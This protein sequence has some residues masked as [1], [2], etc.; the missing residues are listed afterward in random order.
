MDYYQRAEIEGVVE[1]E[2]TVLPHSVQAEI[3]GIPLLDSTGAEITETVEPTYE[4]REYGTDP[5]DSNRY[6][7][8]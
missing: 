5:E 3:L 2:V 8:G 4:R 1:K 7:R 6:R